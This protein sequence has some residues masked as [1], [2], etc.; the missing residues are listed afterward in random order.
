M[1]VGGDWRPG[2][3]RETVRL[4][5]ARRPLDAED[6]GDPMT[7]T[8]TIPDVLDMP[9]ARRV[10]GLRLRRYR[11]ASDH[12]AMTAVFNASR[13]AA[14]VPGSSTVEEMT[15]VYRHLENCDPQT[16]IAIAE[17]D[18]RV[19][20]YGRV[21]WEDRTSG[22]R[23]YTLVTFL[24]PT[25]RGRSVAHAV[26]AWLER[27]A[28]EA[29]RTA[30][31]AR[32]P[33]LLVAYL[34]GDDP[35]RRD[36]LERAGFHIARRHAAMSRPDLEAIPELPL[37]GGLVIRPIAAD[38]GVMHRRVFEV[39]AEVFREHWG[40]SEPTDERFAAFV[41]APTFD[42]PLWRVAFDGDEIAG[43]ILN[44][45]GPLEPDGTRVGWTESIAVRRPW[46]RRGLARA[47]LAASL[48]AVRDAGATSAAL[49]VD[50][51]NPNEALRLYE[52]LG[53]RLVAEELEYHKPL[54]LA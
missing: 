13:R 42:P 39:D 10:P 20:G 22:E 3:F 53:F 46:R 52:S 28:I 19:A 9:E 51:Q 21:Y 5:S 32:R 11:G 23:A 2:L 12:P 29:S 43:Q 24:D 50:Q 1:A 33:A 45:L 27:R 34:F 25:V 7:E 37:P 47:L 40:G 4:P 41:D 15:N 54:P 16:D 6:D 48:R 14:G 18:G 26:L 36:S 38:D 49:G 44:Y 35:D 30:A 8:D 17:L 31:A